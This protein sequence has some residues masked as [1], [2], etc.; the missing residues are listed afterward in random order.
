MSLLPDIVNPA[1][2][3]KWKVRELLGDKPKD[4]DSEDGHAIG[5]WFEAH[6]EATAEDGKVAYIA[7]R[8]VGT[9]NYKRGDPSTNGA[10]PNPYDAQQQAERKRQ[11][12]TPLDRAEEAVRVARTTGDPLSIE[13]A[14]VELAQI[15]TPV[16][17]RL[18][19]VAS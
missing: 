7:N 2:W 4:G 5:A 13:A 18:A 12:M 8:M 9:V 16:P 17:R 1:G 11:G 14:E 10:R 19:S 3:R 15:A 6:P